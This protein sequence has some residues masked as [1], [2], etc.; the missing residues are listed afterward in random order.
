MALAIPQ[1]A[2]QKVYEINAPKTP[3]PIITGKLDIG[4][5]S[6][7]GGSISVNNYYMSIDGKPVIPVMGE[8]H[9]SRYPRE[10]WEEQIVK[11]KAGGVTVLPTY[12]FWALYEEYEDLW[13]WS[14]NHDLR[15][16]IRLCQKHD[17][18]VIIRI[19]PFC[20]GEMRNGSIPD[21]VFAKPL[22]IRSNDP[23]YLKLTRKLYHQIAQQ[24]KG[25][26]Y[27][28]GGPIIGCQLENE[29]QHSAAP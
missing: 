8:F 9:F 12:I 4:G 21:W 13:N 16:F 25:L 23:E 20:H 11:M 26:Y 3:M 14:G 17:M 28:D 7:N 18:P 5:T 22:E 15:H 1:A 19:G 10:Q 24:L 27:K 6:P 2:S 29:M